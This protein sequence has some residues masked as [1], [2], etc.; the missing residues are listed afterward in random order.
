MVVRKRIDAIFVLDHRPAF[1]TGD[2]DYDA[3]VV[4]SS[5]IADLT[6]VGAKEVGSLDKGRDAILRQQTSLVQGPGFQM[7]PIGIHTNRRY[8]ELWETEYS[9]SHRTSAKMQ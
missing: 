4:G 8:R 3:A 1:W 2:A 9:R 6:A 7:M 5:G